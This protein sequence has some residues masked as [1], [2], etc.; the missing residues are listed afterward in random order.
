MSV[1]AEH[2]ASHAPGAA[3]VVIAQQLRDFAA[4]L[5][6]DAKSF[7]AERLCTVLV[8]FG[9]AAQAESIRAVLEVTSDL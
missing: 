7:I 4:N 5:Q 8:E 1:V 9:G 6:S 3:A 2:I